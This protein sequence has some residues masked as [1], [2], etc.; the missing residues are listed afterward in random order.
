MAEK[1]KKTTEKAKANSRSDSARANSTPAWYFLMPILAITFILFLPALKNGFTNWDDVLYVTSN[2]LL[3]ALNGEG[4]K[5][6]FS[7]P[8]VS[9]YH[10]LT[11]LSLAINYQFAELNP[12][13]YHMTS[14][15]LHVINTGLVFW[16]IWVLS[17]GNRWVSAFVALLFGIHP[18]HVES[19]AWISERKDL[20]YTLFYVAAMIAYVQYVRLRQPAKLVLVTV[21]GGLSLLCKPAAIVL[22]LS[23]LAIDYYLR[24]EWS[25]KW[26]LEK[27]PMFLLSGIFAY[28]TLAI[29]AKKAVASVELYSIVE[30]ICFA[31]FGS[32]WYLV[33]AIVPYPLSALHPFP[34][35]LSVVYYLA[36]ALSIAGAIFMLLKVRNR[37][38]L[39]G[40]GFYIINLIL[41][42]QLISIGNA[43]VAERYTYV[44]YIS[45]FF[46]MGMEVH[47][48]LK[49]NLAK[50][51]WIVLGA[52]A[53]WIAA[54]S[55]LTWSRIPVWN[56]S[57]SLWEDVLKQYPESKRAWTNKGL[58]LYDQQ[59]WPEV[60]QHLSKALETDPDYG[61]A[62]EWRSRAYMETKEPAKALV[63]AQKFQKL[64]PQKEA[65]LFILARA[66]DATGAYDAA[67][68]N[69][70][71]LIAT[72]PN[73][74]EYINNRGVIY[75]N[76][77][78][79]YEKAKA[80]FEKAIQLSPQNGS[81][82]LNLSRC[83]YM[84]NDL[85]KAQENARKS[86]DL[87][88][89]VDPSFKQMIGLQ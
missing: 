16:F 88:T 74:P 6:I 72:Y 54:L 66:Q 55:Y 71:T 42:L 26:V 20:L 48:A 70:N 9:N 22:P 2:P 58:D 62:L 43:V 35:E 33:K 87:G 19:V 4:L 31:G 89:T 52:A 46:L 63:D 30:R 44:P 34:E 73:K 3:K 37:N 68:E 5:A 25:W 75:F 80:D 40:F 8:V 12:T 29:Q 21:L 59:K 41:V 1:R 77:L 11:I 79:S 78:R 27:I 28:V 67:V 50:Y 85:P 23:L 49:H 15:L 86:Q 60:I 69:Y 17:S 64:Y 18:M 81:Y 84:L 10:P 57:Q 39:F 14:V 51:K 7:T 45:L 38:Y 36:T 83:H 76:K 53:M 32:I 65:A 24:R 47:N 61:D 82:Y 56:N 13:T